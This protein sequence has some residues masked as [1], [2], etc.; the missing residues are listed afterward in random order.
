MNTWGEDTF[1]NCDLGDQRRTQRLMAMGNAFADN[2]GA[3]MVSACDGDEAQI[4]ATYRFARNKQISSEAILSGGFKSTHDLAIKESSPLLAI[5]DTTTLS[6]SHKVSENLG[7]TSSTDT[8]KARGFHVHSVLLVNPLNKRTVGLIEQRWWIRDKTT[9]GK[10][11]SRKT[12][13]YEDKE[14]FKWQEASQQVSERLGEKMSEVISVCDREADIYDYLS[15][16]EGA[17]QRYIVRAYGNRKISSTEGGKLFAYQESL[18]ILGY[19]SVDVQQKGGRK[20]R[21]PKVE[22]RATSV[23]IQAPSYYGTKRERPKSLRVNVVFATEYI[24]DKSC[25]NSEEKLRWVLLTSEPVNTYEEALRVIRSYELRWRIEDYHKAL[26]SGVGIEKLRLQDKENIKRIGSIMSFLAVRL[27]QMREIMLSKDESS[28]KLKKK[29]CTAILSKEE[30]H[31]LWMAIDKKKLPKRTP[32]MEWAYY[33][34]GK[35]GGWYDSKKT[36]IIGW[37]A[38]WKGWFRLQDKLETFMDTK[39]YL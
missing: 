25:I 32:D 8:S 15:Y 30:W 18:P 14:S 23:D 9:F 21:K 28:M 27:L 19:Y 36:G 38:M 12:E 11:R 16:K 33:A 37:Q 29:P 31:V 39:K 22:L 7:H 2:I 20:S 34:M 1:R 35:L 10:S 13:A 4:E 5:E 24:S 26:K 3:S 17:E 6:Y